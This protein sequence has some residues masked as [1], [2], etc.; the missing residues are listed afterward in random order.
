MALVVKDTPANAG[1]GKDRGLIPELGRH[2]GGGH[3]NQLQCTRLEKLMDRGAWWAKVHAVTKSWIRLK[4]FSVAQY[5]T[6]TPNMFR[7]KCKLSAMT[8]KVLPD[9]DSR[10]LSTLLCW[11]PKHAR[12][13]HAALPSVWKTQAPSHVTPSALVPPLLGELFLSSWT[14]FETPYHASLFKYSCLTEN[15]PWQADLK[16]ASRPSR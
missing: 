5:S 16:E 4:Q 9:L 6:M 2:S 11:L 13:S 14:W 1:S 8:R 7:I 10:H 15:F 12:P 3:G